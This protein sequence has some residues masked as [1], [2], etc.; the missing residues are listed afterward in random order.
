M[1]KCNTLYICCNFSLGLLLQK[2]LNAVF[3]VSLFFCSM[4][5]Y[6]FLCFVI[7]VSCFVCLWCTFVYFGIT[8]CFLLYNFCAFCL[9]LM[10]FYFALLCVRICASVLCVVLSFVFVFCAFEREKK[11]EREERHVRTPRCMYRLGPHQSHLGNEH[12]AQSSRRAEH[13][14]DRYDDEGSILLFSQY[15]R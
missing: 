2:L 3:R 10:H 8:L 12:Q 7:V 14:E 13:Y 9:C 1:L 11:R 4:C 5:M 6:V 15:K